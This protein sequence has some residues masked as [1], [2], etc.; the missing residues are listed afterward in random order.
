MKDQI[1]ELSTH[2]FEKLWTDYSELQV[3]EETQ[4]IF[5][6]SIKSED[7]HLLI[8]PHG[9]N[10]EILSF[11]LRLLISKKCEGF[12]T[13]HL[14]VNDYLEQ[15][16]KKLLQFI[17]TKIGYVKESWKEIILPFFTAYERKKVHSY[18]S[19]KWGNVFTQS[20][21]EWN[22][23]RIHLC[24]KDEKMTIDIDGDDI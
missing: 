14:E 12:I 16:D 17:Q 4:N 5:R 23:R 20:I 11:L 8:G 18:V 7:S 19:E 9:K 13:V 2:F 15:K 6:I 1:Q 22:D 24:R 21:W 10:L 3:T